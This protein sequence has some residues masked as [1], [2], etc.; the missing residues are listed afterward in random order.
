MVISRAAVA[1]TLESSDVMITLEPGNGS[2]IEID[3]S[4]SV[5]KQFGSAIRRIIIETLSGLGISDA[6]VTAIDKGA[7]DCTI[8]ARVKTAVFRSGDP[9]EPQSSGAP[10]EPQTGGAL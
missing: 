1:G 7:L 2:G 4:S 6:K 8:R 5:E 10:A 3:L 9:A